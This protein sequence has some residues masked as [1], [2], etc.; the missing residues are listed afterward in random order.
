MENISF[1]YFPVS[2]FFLCL[3]LF[4]PSVPSLSSFSFFFS[5]LGPRFKLTISFGMATTPFQMLHFVM[6]STGSVRLK[7]IC[8]LVP[9]RMDWKRDINMKKIND[10]FSLKRPV[11]F[12]YPE[13]SLVPTEAP[14]EYLGCILC[15]FGAILGTLG[16]LVLVEIVDR[17]G[18]ALL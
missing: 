12:T 13:E 16:L 5:E 18:G 3:L 10:K 8:T 7:Q 6:K 14:S 11:G 4:P 9:S 2:Q 17:F 15:H 1:I